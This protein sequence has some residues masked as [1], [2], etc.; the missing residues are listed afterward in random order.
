M[1]EILK[2]WLCILASLSLLLSCCGTSKPADSVDLRLTSVGFRRLEIPKQR[3]HYSSFGSTVIRTQKE[4]QAFLDHRW[5]YPYLVPRRYRAAERSLT[6]A[7][8]D[9]EKE[10]LVLL[11]HTERSGSIRVALAR[12]L[13][14]NGVLACEV[15]REGYSL[16]CDMA[17]YCFAFV[18]RNDLIKK[19]ELR[20]GDEKE[21]LQVAQE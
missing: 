16:T 9:F 12:P 2:S 13:V 19:V 8:I 1:G 10:T 11:R 17:H 7:R 14:V 20:V 4:F 18:V 3:S 5:A 15:I 6:A 21:V